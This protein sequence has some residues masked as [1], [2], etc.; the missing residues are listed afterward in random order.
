MPRYFNISLRLRPAAKTWA[1]GPEC[2]APS[3]SRDNLDSIFPSFTHVVA[4]RNRPR[5]RSTAIMNGFIL[6]V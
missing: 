1:W 3:H 6:P 2:V 4:F 5:A